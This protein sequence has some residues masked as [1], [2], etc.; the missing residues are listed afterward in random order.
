MK[1]ERG[2]GRGRGRGRER[3]GEKDGWK[4]KE[5][6]P[7]AAIHSW[8]FWF[9]SN[10]SH[11]PG[12][13]AL[14]SSKGDG[15]VSAFLVALLVPQMNGASFHLHFLFMYFLSERRSPEISQSKIGSC[16]FAAPSLFSFIF[17]SSKLS[18][19][20]LNIGGSERHLRCWQPFKAAWECTEL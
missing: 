13:E 5:S 11:I 14:K 16:E 7:A 17:G 19:L 15:P 1:R 8:Q 2:K 9:H 20:C 18:S 6:A 10:D 12:L 4:Q 3:E